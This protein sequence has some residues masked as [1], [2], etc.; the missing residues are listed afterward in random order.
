MIIGKYSIDCEGERLEDVLHMAVIVPKEEELI[1]Y[2][3]QRERDEA[4][5]GPN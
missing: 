3:V 4:L 1:I 5:D 2:V